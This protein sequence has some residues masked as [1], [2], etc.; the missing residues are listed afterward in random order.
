MVH[1]HILHA[2]A[3]PRSKDILVR[4][5]SNFKLAIVVNMG[6]NDCLSLCEACNRLVISL[7]CTSLFAQ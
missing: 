1:L 6:M 5:S 3:L 7:G 2:H 4:L